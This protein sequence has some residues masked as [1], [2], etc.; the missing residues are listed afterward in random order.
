MERSYSADDPLK[1]SPIL[2]EKVALYA[3][4]PHYVLI[5]G[6]RGTGKTTLAKRLH[7]MSPRSRGAFVSANCASFAS[8]LLESAVRV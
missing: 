2:E 8:D 1:G 3:R 7:E 4:V 6:E 5:T